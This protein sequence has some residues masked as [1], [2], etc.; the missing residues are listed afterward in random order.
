MYSVCV[1][2]R[3][4]EPGMLITT[5]VSRTDQTSSRQ[6]SQQ[7]A[8]GAKPNYSLSMGINRLTKYRPA[9][10]GAA[11]T[12]GDISRWLT[13]LPLHQAYRGEQMDWAR[14]WVLAPTILRF[15]W[16]L[17]VQVHTYR[18]LCG[19]DWTFDKLKPDRDNR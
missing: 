11:L 2:K 12:A 6:L 7:P 9:S 18:T 15:A 5:R 14:S 1:V 4:L 10:E 8:S 17:L 3:T 13:G 19:I 16:T